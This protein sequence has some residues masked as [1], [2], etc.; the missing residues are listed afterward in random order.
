MRSRARRRLDSA[1]RTRRQESSTPNG[2]CTRTVE[3]LTKAQLQIINRRS[4]LGYP[5]DTAEKDHF[6]ALVSKIIHD[7]PIREKLVFKG[8]TA[9][10]HTYLPQMRFSEDL[11]PT[12]LW[13]MPA[14]PG[15][16]TIRS[17]AK[18]LT[19]F[20]RACMG[21]VKIPLNSSIA[22]LTQTRRKTSLAGTDA[23]LG[24]FITLDD[25]E[26]IVWKSGLSGGCNT[27]IGY[28]TQKRRGAL[29]LSNFLWRP[30][31]EG[32]INLGMKVINPDFPQGDFN[33]LY[34][35]R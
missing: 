30:I 9:L 25:K 7:S 8:G 10:H 31:D 4:G 27:C 34:S 28:S 19:V 21:L 6:L 29:I 24:W 11:E 2:D 18:D 32:T 3:L 14:M 26:E 13:D 23:G 35:S 20:L 16:G 33:A 1:K 12:R 15:A 5:L 17:N 22:R